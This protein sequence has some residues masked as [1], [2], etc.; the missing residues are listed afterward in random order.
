MSTLKVRDQEPLRLQ[1]SDEERITV[2]RD[3][4]AAPEGGVDDNVAEVELSEKK[5]G[6]KVTW[7]SLPHRRQLIILTLARLS[8]PLVQTSLQASTNFLCS[9]EE[10]STDS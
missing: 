4:D 10:S 6:E 2:L 8:E 5:V 7:R 3:E 9:L 1:T